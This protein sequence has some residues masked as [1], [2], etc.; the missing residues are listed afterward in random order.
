MLQM[1]RTVQGPLRSAKLGAPVEGA[2]FFKRPPQDQVRNGH[3]G[4]LSAFLFSRRVRTISIEKTPSSVE[5][6]LQARNGCTDGFCLWGQKRS[7]VVGYCERYGGLSGKPR[8][9]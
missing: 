7:I 8:E 3:L 1:S 2:S 4:P 5:H 9:N 6:V